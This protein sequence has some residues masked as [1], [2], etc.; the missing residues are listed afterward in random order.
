[1]FLHYFLTGIS[2]ILSVGIIKNSCIVVALMFLIILYRRLSI[3]MLSGSSIFSSYAIKN[4]YFYI[5]SGLVPGK[6]KLPLKN[7][8]S[9][10]V[11]LIRGI[12]CNGDRYHVL[13]S[14]RLGRDKAFFLIT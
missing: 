9:V 14:M 6:R 11:N 7:M 5:H 13:I 3:C 2:N 4:G 8:E 10:D 12:K 1:M